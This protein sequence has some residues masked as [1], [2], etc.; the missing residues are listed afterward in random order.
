LFFDSARETALSPVASSLGADPIDFFRAL[1]G[2]GEH[3][4][5]VPPA[6]RESSRHCQV[7]L[8]AP[9]PVHE[10]ADPQRGEESHVP[11]QHA[12]VSLAAGDDDLIH[13]LRWKLAEWGGE[14]GAE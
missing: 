11:R 5:L 6:L 14:H 7:V 1:G 9:G 3:D 2:T 8:V 13:R 10:L 4:D 12:E